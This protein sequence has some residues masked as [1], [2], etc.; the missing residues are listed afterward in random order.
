LSHLYMFRAYQEVE[1]MY[2][3]NGTCY[4]VQLTVSSHIYTFFLL[5]MGC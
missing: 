5:M 1:C 3:A 2:V 4:T